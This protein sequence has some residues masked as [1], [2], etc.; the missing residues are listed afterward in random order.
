MNVEVF[1]EL[2]F[3][4]FSIELTD[5]EKQWFASDGKELRGSISKGDCRGEVVV[6]V[7]SHNPRSVHGQAFYNGMKESERPCVSD[8][9]RNEIHCIHR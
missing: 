1:S 9:D 6:Q 2:V 8:I 3:S 4:F 7:V 5:K